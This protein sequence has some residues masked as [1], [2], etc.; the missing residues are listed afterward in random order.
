MQT[1][2]CRGEALASMQECSVLTVETRHTGGSGTHRK[3]MRAGQVLEFGLARRPRATSG[4]SVSVHDLFFSMPV[5]RKGIVS[6]LE[7]EAV[8]RELERIVLIN[9]HVSIT[10][11][12]EGTT[13]PLLRT[14]PTR[15]IHAMFTQLF[16][17]ARSQALF[18]LAADAHHVRGENGGSQHNSANDDGDDDDDDDRSPPTKPGKKKKKRPGGK[19]INFQLNERNLVCAAA[20]R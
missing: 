3:V 18:P 19:E 11:T 7:T 16:G 15:S 4:T 8:Q 17:E 14:Q 9:P 6:A 13:A 1:Y 12:T 10:L 20:H 2:G 5:R